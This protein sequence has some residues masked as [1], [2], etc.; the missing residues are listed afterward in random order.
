[1][2][3]LHLAAEHQDREILSHLLMYGADVNISVSLRMLTLVFLVGRGHY[4]KMICAYA[5]M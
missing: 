4:P 2:S 5:G 1:M 3:C